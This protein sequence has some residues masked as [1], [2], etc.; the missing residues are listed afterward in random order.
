[1]SLALASVRYETHNA[2]LEFGDLVYLDVLVTL[3]D[4]G[5]DL[6]FC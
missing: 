6:G 5:S 1:M 2:R 4:F 3:V